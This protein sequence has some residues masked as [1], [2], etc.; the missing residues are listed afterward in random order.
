MPRPLSL[1]LL[2]TL[3]AGCPSEPPN[4]TKP[5]PKRSPGA[6]D[7]TAT[8]SAAP[9]SAPSASARPASPKPDGSA[10]PSAS[11][12]VS[13]TPIAVAPLVVG[14]RQGGEGLPASKLSFDQVW[15][16]A[17]ETDGGLL[18]SHM[19][20]LQRITKDGLLQHVSA[21]P[22]DTPASLEG[23]AIKSASLRLPRA[24]GREALGRWLVMEPQRLLRLELDGKLT[25]LW[26]TEATSGIAGCAPAPNGDVLVLIR[27][28]QASDPTFD[29]YAIKPDK[30]RQKIHT[31]TGDNEAVL[32]RL[33]TPG[34][35]PVGSQ[36]VV[37]P[38][39]QGGM[40]LW[41][42]ATGTGAALYRFAPD[43]K[44]LTRLADAPASGIALD[45]AG[46][47]F[48]HVAGTRKL[49]VRKV[50]GTVVTLTENLPEGFRPVAATL[51]SDGAAYVADWPLGAFDPQRI[52]RIKNGEVTPLT[53]PDGVLPSKLDE[54]DLDPWGLAVAANGT[55]Y[56]GD[57]GQKRILKVAPGGPATLFGGKAGGAA[58][59]DGLKADAVALNPKA[60]R[61]DG[62]GNLYAIHDRTPGD[63][64][65]KLGPDGAIKVLHTLTNAEGASET[66]QA[67]D[68]AVSP[69]GQVFVLTQRLKDGAVQ[70]SAIARLEGTGSQSL[71]VPNKVVAA[72]A[73]APDGALAM[74]GY[75]TA[76]T[77]GPTPHTMSRWTA[78]KG[79]VKLQTFS[80]VTGTAS[81][82]G[83]AIAPGGQFIMAGG[84]DRGTIFAIDPVNGTVQTLVGEGGSHFLGKTR[85]E[86]V[87]APAFPAFDGSGNLYFSDAYQK[88]VKAIRADDL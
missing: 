30:T 29:V 69:E 6:S 64:T 23:A 60:L 82:Q 7:V 52:V 72:I 51:G 10:S 86:G 44:A 27:R 39:G 9:S 12:S 46:N 61:L 66:D 53:G 88:Q 71:P 2:A 48:L 41:V 84:P 20:R 57:V 16:L 14:L 31:F 18:V 34:F 50:D 87:R 38:D 47:L 76:S 56:V 33:V 8:P 49:E 77:T 37:A 24:R 75:E 85:D 63:Q 80:R 21:A 40:L 67:I 81:G 45:G 32:D 35:V 59:A 15:D 68:L 22:F 11:P 83:L 55:V 74:V 70:S 43:T 3:L 17:L 36:D 26:P 78:E 79:L 25:E 13:P 19:G 4:A 58:P 1:L 65:L 28:G 62:A 54:V 73:I 5:A 42:G